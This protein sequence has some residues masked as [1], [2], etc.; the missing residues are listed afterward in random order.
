[1]F[2]MEMTG[3]SPVVLPNLLAKETAQRR[4][5]VY[6]WPMTGNH[7]LVFWSGVVADDSVTAA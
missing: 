6:V 5:G 7:S 1:M 2:V 4:L 3:R